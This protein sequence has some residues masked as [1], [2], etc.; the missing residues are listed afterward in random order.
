MIALNRPP[1]P[2][3]IQNVKRRKLEPPV[4]PKSRDTTFESASEDRMDTDI[5]ANE[6][7]CGYLHGPGEDHGHD[8]TAVGL[9]SNLMRG[10]A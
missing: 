3:D 4:L 9:S 5:S 7:P 1:P 10:P 8:I 2:L 6:C